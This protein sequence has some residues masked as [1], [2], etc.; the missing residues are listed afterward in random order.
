MYHRD[1]PGGRI[2]QEFR[3]PTLHQIFQYFLC[4]KT[5][6]QNNRIYHCLVSSL[7]LY[8]KISFSVYHT[9]KVMMPVLLYDLGLINAWYAISHNSS[10]TRVTFC[11]TS[12]F[13]FLLSKNKCTNLVKKQ[14]VSVLNTRLRYEIFGQWRI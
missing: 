8:F 13:S 14:S 12:I 7:L 11:F 2:W 4:I 9:P 3:G 1:F 6:K 10:A 5:F